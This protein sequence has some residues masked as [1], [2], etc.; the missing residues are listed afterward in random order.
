M[1]N[2]WQ[3]HTENYFKEEKDFE[4]IDSGCTF[5]RGAVLNTKY[6]QGHLNCIQSSDYC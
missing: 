5:L 1:S 4:T 2:C 3:S 6:A